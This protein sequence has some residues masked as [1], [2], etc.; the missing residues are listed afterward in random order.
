MVPEIWCATDRWTDRRTDRKSD[1]YRWVSHLKIYCDCIIHCSDSTDKLVSPE[2][3][4]S[5]N[6]ILHAAKICNHK[7]VLDVAKEID[8]STVQGIMY[9]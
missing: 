6:V 7:A 4:E 1:I 8:S 3:L 5:L 9:H 2:S